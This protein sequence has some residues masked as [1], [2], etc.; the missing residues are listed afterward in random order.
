MR[1]KFYKNLLLLLVIL[2]ILIKIC[3]SSVDGFIKHKGG[4]VS[5]AD[6]METGYFSALDKVMEDVLDNPNLTPEDSARIVADMAST[7]ALLPADNKNVHKMQQ[8]IGKNGKQFTVGIM[9]YGNVLHN[10]VKA[11]KSGVDPSNHWPTCLNK[12][13][14]TLRWNVPKEGAKWK[15]L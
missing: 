10:F 6:L 9:G 15:S 2:S 7:H 3:M 1:H 8:V 4:I 13:I 11:D 12:S 5:F 14:L